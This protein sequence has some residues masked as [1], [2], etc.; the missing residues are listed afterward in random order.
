SKSAPIAVTN[1]QQRT[2]AKI[3]GIFIGVGDYARSKPKQNDLEAAQNAE[4]LAQVWEKQRDTY[5]AK[6]EMR[7]LKD[8]QV[9]AEK[10][11]QEVDRL[12]AQV[13]PDDL[14]VFYLA[15]HGF[16]KQSEFFDAQ[17]PGVG[18]F[19]ILCGNCDVLR[20]RET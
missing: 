8:K 7:V 16:S 19:F 15:G 3:R 10:L 17:I 9:T 2:K 5:R 1:K 13:Q 11:F 12:A 20:L 4:V 18:E 14:L 6:G